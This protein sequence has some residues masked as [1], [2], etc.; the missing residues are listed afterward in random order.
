MTKVYS[1]QDSYGHKH[2][3][4]F[5]TALEQYYTDRFKK[6]NFKK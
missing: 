6:D 3:V 5:S 4:V 2:V 1:I